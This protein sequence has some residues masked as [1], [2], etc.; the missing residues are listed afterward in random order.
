MDKLLIPIFER[1]RAQVPELLHIDVDLGQLRAENP[2][3][4]WPCA[5]VGIENIDYAGRAMQTAAVTI[6]VTLGFVI[7]DSS[8]I[9]SAGTLRT[10]AMEHF[11][12]I[13][14]VAEALHGFETENF[15]PLMRTRMSPVQEVYPR[16]YAL[17]FRTQFTETIQA[18]KRLYAVPVTIQSRMKHAGRG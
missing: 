9:D 8:E 10:M 2:P 4:D 5:L 11:A 3:V 1:L 18:E 6:S 13:R 16:Q 15:A 17:T 12:V 14:K 7:W